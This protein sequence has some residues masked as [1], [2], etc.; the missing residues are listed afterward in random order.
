MTPPPRRITSGF[1]AHSRSQT[2]EN[3]QAVPMARGKLE[4]RSSQSSLRVPVGRS[5][6]GGMLAP[7]SSTSASSSSPPRAGL[8][9]AT[10]AT[11][12]ATAAAAASGALLSE[13]LSS[14]SVVSKFREL[15]ASSGMASKDRLPKRLA[16]KQLQHKYVCPYLFACEV[17][18]DHS[19]ATLVHTLESIQVSHKYSGELWVSGVFML[20]CLAE[21]QNHNA[22]V[23]V[24]TASQLSSRWLIAYMLGRRASIGTVGAK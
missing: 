23:R 22:R 1:L 14:S 4:P 11:A 7:P 19:N 6:V 5:S 21:I 13:S 9:A 18:P 12:A 10:A 20:E 2:L 15:H 8:H 24:L 17:S 16:Q 3:V